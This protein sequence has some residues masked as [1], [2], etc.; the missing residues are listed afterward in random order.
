MTIFT[1]GDDCSGGNHRCDACGSK[2]VDH[3]APGCKCPDTPSAAAQPLSTDDCIA[4]IDALSRIAKARMAE[5][6]PGI[7]GVLGGSEFDFMTSDE[8]ALLHELKLSLPSEGQLRLEAKARIAK[9]IQ[10][11]RATAAAFTGSPASTPM[12]QVSA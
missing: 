12:Q 9:R 4:Q 2:W 1:R 6:N 5:C 7:A 8:R 10:D 3:L 11:R